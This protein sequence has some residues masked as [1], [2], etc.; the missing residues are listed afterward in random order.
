MAAHLKSRGFA[1]G[2]RIATLSKNC[3]DCFMAEI[4]IWM[5][6]GTTVA[7]FP[8]ESAQNIK[9]VLEH[10]EASSLFLGELD[11]W[12]QQSKGVPA[13][14][15]VFHFR[16]RRADLAARTARAGTPRPTYAAI[17]RATGARAR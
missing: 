12:Q 10:A 1:P 5:A 4:A 16:M 15:L 3:A 8:T 14:C 9:Y 7:L 11:G 2:A 17:G 13:S 6:G